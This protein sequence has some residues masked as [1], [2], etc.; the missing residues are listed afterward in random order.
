[1]F[2][3]R[4]S[5]TPSANISWYKDN[6][7]VIDRT[8]KYRTYPEGVLEIYNVEFRDFGNYYCAE[9]ADKRPKSRVARLSQK[10]AGKK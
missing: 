2:Q 6:Q 1:M 10:K 8:S 9:G 3:C 4:I 7:L 5:A